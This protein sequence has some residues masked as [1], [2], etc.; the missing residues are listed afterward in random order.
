MR[1]AGTL[2]AIG[3]GRFPLRKVDRDLDIGVGISGVQDANGFVAYELA[4][5]SCARWGNVPF[6]YRPH[7]MPDR[8]SHDWLL[9]FQRSCQLCS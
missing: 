1:R 4:R 5:V 8:L 9:R 6:R 7:A 2:I 3:T